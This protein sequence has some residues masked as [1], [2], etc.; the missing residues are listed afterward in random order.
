MYVWAGTVT[1][2]FPVLSRP[3]PQTEVGRQHHRLICCFYFWECV[4]LCACMSLYAPCSLVPTEN[5]RCLMPYVWFQIPGQGTEEQILHIKADLASRFSQHPSVP[6]TDLSSPGTEPPS[7]RG[8]AHITQTFGSLSPFPLSAC[9][10][11]LC[12]SFPSPLPPS[13]WQ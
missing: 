6:N 7:R 9:V 1:K 13:S 2:T 10:L 11:F 3:Q 8:S 4:C 5:R 12:F